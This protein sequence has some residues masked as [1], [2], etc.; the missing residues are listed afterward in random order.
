MH[1]CR[2]G[3]WF[4]FVLAVA[5]CGSQSDSAY[6]EYDEAEMQAAIA[7]A[8]SSVNQFI[9]TLHSGNG[10]NF[11]VKVAIQDGD[12]VEH[13]WLSN[14]KYADGKFTGTIDNAPDMISNV[15][16]GQQWTV[17]KNEISDWMFIRDRKMHGNFTIRPLLK[18]F[19]EDE[20]AQFRAILAEP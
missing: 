12:E 8:K 16:M 15:Q 10:E 7:Q 11:S 14:V 3:L 13:M 9:D 6:T 4:G 19:P 20:A 17:P 2:L 5:G 18:T 1:I